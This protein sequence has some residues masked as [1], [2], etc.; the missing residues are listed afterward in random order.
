MVR[1]VSEKVNRLIL[2]FILFA[3]IFMAA[4]L[5]LWA[6]LYT[7]GH[8]TDK[9]YTGTTPWGMVPFAAA[10]MMTTVAYIGTKQKSSKQKP[11]QS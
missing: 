11:S 10:W 6:I 2:R 9:Q 3:I 8:I 1:E 5:I 4:V 7:A